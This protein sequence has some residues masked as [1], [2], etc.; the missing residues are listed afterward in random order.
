[1]KK[2]MV[3]FLVFLTLHNLV[4]IQPL[5]EEK[6]VF[7]WQIDA[8]EICEVDLLEDSSDFWVAYSDE[9]IEQI[10]REPERY[11]NLWIGSTLFMNNIPTEKFRYQLSFSSE[12]DHGVIFSNRVIANDT[13]AEDSFDG[14]EKKIVRINLN[15][16]VDT[17]I[18]SP[19]DAIHWIASEKVLSLKVIQE[20][21]AIGF[22]K[23]FEKDFFKLYSFSQTE[24]SRFVKKDIVLP[25]GMKMEVEYHTFIELEPVFSDFHQLTEDNDNCYSASIKNIYPVPQDGSTDES[26]EWLS[27]RDQNEQECW[28]IVEVQINAPETVKKIIQAIYIQDEYGD[29]FNWEKEFF[30]LR[31]SEYML[32]G[33]NGSFQIKM[34]SPIFGTD[35]EIRQFVKESNLK[36]NFS[37]EPMSFYEV[38]HTCVGFLN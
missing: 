36:I 5:V 19:T 16:F 23:P 13:E 9:Q 27:S 4:C 25:K 29:V 7:E 34:V 2:M 33:E 1:M 30:L 11:V 8:W 18:C 28:W 6:S 26:K 3:F 20:K 37:F 31:D 38:W 14:R 10:Q 21:L 12:N 35:F 24:L 32:I 17:S 15:L 22:G